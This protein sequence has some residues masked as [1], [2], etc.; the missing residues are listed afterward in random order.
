MRQQ[1]LLYVS[2]SHAS[3]FQD[4]GQLLSAEVV[5]DQSLDRVVASRPAQQDLA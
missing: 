5:G 3:F 4:P 2:C 1:P